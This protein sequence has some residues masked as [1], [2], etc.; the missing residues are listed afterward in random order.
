MRTCALCDRRDIFGR[1]C[2]IGATV[3]SPSAVKIQSCHCASAFPFVAERVR[4]IGSGGALEKIEI[5]YT[6]LLL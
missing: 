4:L 6:H 1:I 5:D 3:K 2:E